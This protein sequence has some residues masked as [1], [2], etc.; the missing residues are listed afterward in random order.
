MGDHHNRHIPVQLGCSLAG[1]GMHTTT[2]HINV[3]EP[4]AFS[5][6]AFP[7]TPA[8]EACAGQVRQQGGCLLHQPPRGH[9][10]V[11]LRM[12]QHPL[13]WAAP[14]SVEPTGCA[15]LRRSQ[16]CGRLSLLQQASLRGVEAVSGGC[17][18]KLADIQQG[19]D[20]PVPLKNINPL[21]SLVLMDRG[22]C[23]SNTG[24][25]GPRVA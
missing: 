7:P 16:S 3:L 2:H 19:R 14:P 5:P 4:W 11:L 15:A 1:S 21:P 17:E 12:S 22:G 9:K 18:E 8:G 23:P 6:R 20:G 25:P 24:C 13:T 10:I